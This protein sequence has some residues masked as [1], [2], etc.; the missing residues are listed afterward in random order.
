[1]PT[2]LSLFRF[3]ILM[4]AAATATSRA[5]FVEFTF[6]LTDADADAKAS[7]E[8]LLR[9]VWADV[10]LPDGKVVSYPAFHHE[11]ATWKVRVRSELA[12]N[13]R[14][15]A[16]LDRNDE[17][18][19][20]PRE[21]SKARPLNATFA[22]PREITV[23]AP[24]AMPPVR[25]NPEHPL[26]FEFADGRVYFPI[27]MNVG[28]APL[29]GPGSYEEALPK[30]HELGMNWTRIWMTH[31]AGLA[32][33][34]NG[35]K[36]KSPRPGQIDA[37]AARNWDRLV[38]LA[39]RNGIYF[40]MVLQHHGQFSTTTNP[41]WKDN[42][43]NAA[44]KNGFLKSPVDFFSDKKARQLT[45]AKY[46]YIVARYGHSPA[47]LAWEL[48][49]EVHWTDGARKDDA[50]VG[51]WHDEMAAW[52]RRCDP[53]RHPVTTSHDDVRSAVFASMDY[54]QP[55]LYAAN[56]LAGTRVFPFAPPPE[57]RGRPMFYGEI[58]DDKVPISKDDKETGIALIP[59]IWTS[60]MAG[61]EVQPGQTWYWKRIYNSAERRGEMRAIITFIA[62][63]RLAE[64]N[65]SLAP[66]SP[67]VKTD[68]TVPR[69]LTPGYEWSKRPF[70]P[71][72][73]PPDGRD[74][75]ALADLPGALVG[76][77]NH[78][79]NGYANA[80]EIRFVKTGAQPVEITIDKLGREGGSLRVLV[81]GAIAQD[82]NWPSNADAQTLSINVPA[83]VRS[84]ILQNSGETPQAG[85]ISI[86]SINLTGT[87]P[88]L[89]AAGRRDGGAVILYLWHRANI[90]AIAPAANTSA[91]GT[92]IL[93]NLPRGT[94]KIT[95]WNMREGGPESQETITHDG[96]NFLLKTPAILRHAAVIMEKT[97]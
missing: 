32:L 35:D 28:W 10:S 74:T 70:T 66:F 15:A 33:D 81:D 39:E 90:L 61:G 56:M 45:R 58:G 23:A 80:T 34:W 64:R 96:G 29:T 47:I 5:D 85:T 55:H 21:K 1:M 65:A 26:R 4:L 20:T 54:Y 87:Q 94:W 84:L 97:N 95:W 11:G 19:A 24:S 18:P 31:W 67:A 8:P 92:V 41:N 78:R 88:A 62:A 17:P 36:N 91:Q 38:E 25:I 6:T 52:L 27:G 71:V 53:W 72:I 46:R 2:P 44:N 51:R 57:K 16:A 14:I 7:S 37:N 60:L 63:T 13:Y 40:Q 42:P 49:N 3:L 83:G 82:Y 73:I 75:T 93:E 79:K 12:G 86:K 43:L 68:A 50:L 69:I 89:A 77:S 59:P 48:F 9:D 22:E 30:M 76:L